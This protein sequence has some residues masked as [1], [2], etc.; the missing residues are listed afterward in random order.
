MKAPV[1]F[2]TDSP[3]KMGCLWTQTIAQGVALGAGSIEIWPKATLGGFDGFMMTEMQ[4]LASELVTPIAVDPNPMP[5]PL[6]C[7]GF[8]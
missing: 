7:S 1:S 2:Q 5:L 8:H 6:P 4:Q 3:Q